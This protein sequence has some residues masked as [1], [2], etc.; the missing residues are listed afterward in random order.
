MKLP[1]VLSEKMHEVKITY[2][3]PLLET[4]PEVKSSVQAEA[5]F[6][7]YIEPEIIDHKEYEMKKILL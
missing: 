6:R 1:I 7:N 4:M 5:V 2:V 3:R